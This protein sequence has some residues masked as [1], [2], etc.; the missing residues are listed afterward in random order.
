[1]TSLAAMPP[2]APA[3]LATGVPG[4]DTASIPMISQPTSPLNAPMTVTPSLPCELL[5]H[6]I[7]GRRAPVGDRGVTPP[8]RSSSRVGPP[9]MP[10][11]RT[12]WR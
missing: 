7:R 9:A 2:S 6:P 8:P 12:P 11:H 1:M 4:L 10:A 5:P 3:R